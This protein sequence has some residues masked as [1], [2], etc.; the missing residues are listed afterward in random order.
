MRENNNR[1]EKRGY[2]ILGVS[3]A[4]G[5]LIFSGGA[6]QARYDYNNWQPA[7]G[8]THGIED[9]L[10]ARLNDD[11]KRGYIDTNELAQLRRDLDGIEAQE[12][13]FRI[14]HN[15]L[16]VHDRKC[17]SNKLKRFERNLSR[18]ES[19]KFEFTIASN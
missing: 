15:G 4:L 13:E 7:L 14:D 8:T 1:T 2:K 3:L 17:L 12:D 18:A 16:G 11:Y 6:A 19:D 5:A 9:S 10:E